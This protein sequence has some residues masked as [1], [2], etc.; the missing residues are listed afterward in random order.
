[1]CSSDLKP[2]GAGLVCLDRRPGNNPRVADLLGS[3][4]TVLIAQPQNLASP[5]LHNRCSFCDAEQTLI[6]QCKSPSLRYASSAVSITNCVSTLS[7]T[8]PFQMD[9]YN[10][11]VKDKKPFLPNGKTDILKARQQ[12][13]LRCKA[14]HERRPISFISAAFSL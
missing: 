14:P 7:L 10:Y 1:M 13:S 8:R 12:E 4:Q 2:L 3:I 11:T 5:Q 9:C 6:I